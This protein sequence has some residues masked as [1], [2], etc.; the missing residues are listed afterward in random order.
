MKNLSLVLNAV[1]LIAVAFLFVRE[2]SGDEE[3]ASPKKQPD[4]EAQ[5][6]VV[7]SVN[8]DTLYA[9]YDYYQDIKSKIEQKSKKASVDLESRASKFAKKR[10]SFIKQAQAGLL[11]N[12]EAQKRE[13]QLMQ[14]GQKLERYKTSAQQGLVAFEQEQQEKLYETITEFIEEYNEDKGYSYIVGYQYGGNFWY[15]EDAYDITQDVLEGLNAQYKAEQDSAESA[16]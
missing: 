6:G 12:N 9:Y 14:E 3:E 15:T 1:L 2:F 16:E 13:Q 4:S 10:D 11:S 5:A 7:A 8:I